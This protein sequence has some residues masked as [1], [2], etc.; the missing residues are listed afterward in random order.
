MTLRRFYP[1]IVLAVLASP[2]VATAANFETANFVVEAPSPELARKFGEMA[3]FYRKEKALEWLGHEM[4]QWSRKCPLQVQVSMGSA[5]GAT[6]FTF[7]SDQ[8]GRPIVSSQRMEIRGDAKQLL[9][10]VLPH[11]VTHTVLAQHF[12][13]PVPRWADEGGSVLSENDEERFSHDV[14]CREI[15]NAG[16]AF[17]L[18]TLFRM[19]EYPR[20]MTVL[21]AQGYSVTAYL[22]D[23][24]GSG[25]E[26]RGK[27]LQFLG[28]GMNGN[29]AESWNEA[30]RR[31][32]GYESVDGLERAWLDALRTPPAR[33]VARGTQPPAG[34]KSPTFA[35][36]TSNGNRTELRTSAAPTMPLLE[37]PVRAVRGAAPDREPI[38]PVGARP[39]APDYPPPV[40]GPPELPR[41]GR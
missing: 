35:N 10:S 2:S 11:E 9:N 6:T 29:T 22:V 41:T 7:G 8:S 26:G 23:K 38:R 15:L 30:A 13:R 37:P 14:R 17:V 1:A 24:G 36:A 18:R 39:Q 33:T 40:L 16:R 25:R 32:Y 5:G 21:Y 27:L 34:D 28:T 12:G 4:P 20:D 19:T 3:E 31:V